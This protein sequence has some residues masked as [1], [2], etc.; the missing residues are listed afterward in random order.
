LAA[1]PW[2][3]ELLA[4]TFHSFAPRA[5]GVIMKKKEKKTALPMATMIETTTEATARSYEGLH[6]RRR[7]QRLL[8]LMA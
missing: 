3:P 7:Q 2:E 4:N 8:L 6:R 1:G 5:R